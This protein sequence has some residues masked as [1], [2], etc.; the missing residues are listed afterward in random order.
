MK[1]YFSLFAITILLSSCFKK[2]IADAM[3]ETAKGGTASL[4]YDINGTPVNVSVRDADNQAGVYYLL[5]CQKSNGYYALSAAT[6][7]GEFSF[8][9]GTDSLKV[10]NYKAAPASGMYIT[11]Y[12]GQPCFVAGAT[13]NMNFNVT[14]YTNGRISGNFTGQ[15]T[16]A[17]MQGTYGNVYGTYGSV[18]I[19][20]GSFSNVPVLY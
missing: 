11:D 20:H 16:P 18:V 19:T 12:K 14:S 1:F 13:D 2:S 4:S 10:G 8:T 9:F 17:V 6:G 3:L 7:N 5:S 15:I